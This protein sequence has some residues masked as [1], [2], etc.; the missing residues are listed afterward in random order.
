MC[1]RPAEIEKLWHAVRDNR[2]PHAWKEV[3]FPTAAESLSDF[4]IELCHKLDYWRKVTGRNAGIE[5][6]KILWLP[7]FFEPTA[8]LEAFR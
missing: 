6:L 7:A 2:L 4:L 3:S 5:G 8:L 1:S